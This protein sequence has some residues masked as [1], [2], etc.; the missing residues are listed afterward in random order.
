MAFFWAE[1]PCAVSEP[2]A[3]STFPPA[4]PLL[5]PPAVEVVVLSEPQAASASV[6]V[7][8]M[9]A[10]MPCRFRFTSCP[11]GFPVRTRRQE[12]AG[13]RV[14]AGVLTDLTGTLRVAGDRTC[15]LR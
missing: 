13:T 6:A 1:E 11:F 15:G 8:A 3:Q 7:S 4:G 12:R 5:P 14:A 9:P 10:M 2:V